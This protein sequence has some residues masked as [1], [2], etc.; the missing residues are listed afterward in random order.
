[1]QER[2]ANQRRDFWHKTT[3]DLARTYSL[4][5]VEVL[6]LSFMT[7]NGKLSLSAHD[8]SL[9]MFRQM[10]DYKVENTGSQIVG[11][12]PRNT[13]QACSRC[14]VIVAKSLN[15]RV[16]RC[17]D[18]GVELDRDVNAALNILALG[19][20]VRASTYSNGDCVALEAPPIDRGE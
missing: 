12:N 1:L 15:V 7:R 17:P 18:C 9:A 3:S 14:G 8:A 11:V 19:L 16:H 2:V 6:N 5:A 20:S 4:I 13:S 10:L